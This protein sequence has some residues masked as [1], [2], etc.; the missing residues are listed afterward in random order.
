LLKVPFAPITM[1]IDGMYCVAHDWLRSTGIDL[2]I[3][4][5]DSLKHSSSIV[6]GLI[7][8]GIAVDGANAEKFNARVVSGEEESVGILKFT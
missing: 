5:P 7:E 8:R 3:A 1:N 4:F 2:D 6:Y